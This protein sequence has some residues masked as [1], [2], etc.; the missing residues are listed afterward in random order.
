MSKCP[1]CQH[2]L[3]EFTMEEV[4]AILKSIPGLMSQIGEEAA[5]QYIKDKEA[6]S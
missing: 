1:Y 6:Q 5:R 3:P 2:E 4:M